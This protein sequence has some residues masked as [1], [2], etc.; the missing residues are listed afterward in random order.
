MSVPGCRWG[1]VE[2]RR[3]GRSFRVLGEFPQASED[4]YDYPAHSDNDK[5]HRENNG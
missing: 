1:F 2:L 5:Y 4:L 3:P